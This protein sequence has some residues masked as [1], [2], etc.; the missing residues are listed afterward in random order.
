[1][2]TRVRVC[3]VAFTD[4][5]I[6]NRNRKA[7]CRG[8]QNGCFGILFRNVKHKPHQNI[9]NAEIENCADNADEGELQEAFD[10]LVTM[11]TIA[12][13]ETT[14][15]VPQTRSSCKYMRNSTRYS[16]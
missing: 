10:F 15:E 11:P 8:N 5:V 13:R 6:D 7:N 2:R 16:H 9:A 12:H 3:P 14:N 4:K 1:M